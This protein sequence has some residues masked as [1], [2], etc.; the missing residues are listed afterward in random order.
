MINT[1]SLVISISWA[2]LSATPLVSAQDVKSSEAQLSL[3]RPAIIQELRLQPTR[4]LMFPL[5]A[6]P[7]APSWAALSA[8]PLIGAQD[9][10]TSE[11]KFRLQRPAIIQELQL[12]PTRF[13]T[14]PLRADPWAPSWAVLSAAPLIGAQDVKTSEPKLS[15]QSSTVIQELQLQPTR[16]LMSP[17]Q[18]DT[19]MPVIDP[20]DLSRYREFQ[21]GMN[22]FAV[23]KQAGVVPSEVRVIHERPALIQELE[24]RPQGSLSSSPPADPVS[25]V[26]FSFYNGDLFRIVVNYDR[27]RTEGLT[28]EDMVNAISAKYGTAT[29]PGAK[30]I[31]FSSF[32][33]Y[34]DNEKVIAR[35]EDSQYS[36]NLFRSSYQRAFGM[37]V[38]SKQLDALAQAAIV[39]AIRLDEQEAPQREI[40][41]QKQEDEANRAEQDAARLANK[42]AFRL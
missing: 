23:A 14:F 41:R 12:Q 17:L 37:L 33:V 26:L 36:F 4:F 18:M 19:E 21:L 20:Q 16:F 34:N 25:E 40:E 35:W 11:P 22:L 3:Q 10:K 29:R 27:H 42:A 24:W 13:F 7:W 31:L 28:D 1:R 5:Q 8:A 15:P 30:I 6:D 32:A 2:L 39:E 9:V 38:F